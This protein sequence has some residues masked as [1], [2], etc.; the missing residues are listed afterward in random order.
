MNGKCETFDLRNTLQVPDLRCNLLFVGKIVDKGYLGS[1]DKE[2]AKIID[3]AGKDRFTA[4]GLHIRA[5]PGKRH[6]QER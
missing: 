6:I 4:D 2:N 1:F 5:R 3:T